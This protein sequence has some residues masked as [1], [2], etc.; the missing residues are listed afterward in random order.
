MSASVAKTERC[1]LVTG[2]SSGIGLA[3]AERL[4]ANGYRVFATVRKQA[5]AERLNSLGSNYIEPILLEVTCRESI[6]AALQQIQRFTGNAGL[7]GLVN[8]AGILVPGPLELLS[9]EEIR[10]QLE[11]NVLGTHAVTQAMLPLL[12]QAPGRIVMVGSISGQITPPFYGAYSA[13]KHALEAMSDALRIELQPWRVRVSIIQPDTV[14]TGIWSKLSNDL[15]AL[16]QRLEESQ[17]DSTYDQQFQQALK[18]S[19]KSDRKG[20]SVETVVR[21]VQHA[22]ESSRP[23]PRYRVGWRTHLAVWG[24]SFVPQAVMD[25]A[26]RRSV[27]FH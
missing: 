16:K 18:A 25:W 4:A 15:R 23:R 17:A 7:W 22:L 20:L 11:V 14:S 9:T 27:G 1:V 6:Q 26:L 2:C 21:A 19:A 12:R 8:N 5:D 10:R 13:S 3:C 24:D